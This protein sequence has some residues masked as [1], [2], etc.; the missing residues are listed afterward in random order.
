MSISFNPVK[1]RMPKRATLSLQLTNPLG[2]ADLLAHGSSN[3]RGWGQ[4]AFPDQSLLYVRGFDPATQ[5]YR[6]EVNQRFGATNQAL[7]GFRTP[8]TL[9]A[10]LRFDVGPTRERQLLTQQLNRGRTTEGN[11][12]PEQFIKAIYGTG[13]IPNPMSTILRQQDSLKLSS[14]QADSIAGMNRAYLIQTDAIWTPVAKYFA[15]LPKYYDQGVAY[16]RYMQARKA[17]VDLLMK[18]AP[19][20]KD[21]LS[22]EQRRKLPP[23]VASYLEPRYLASIRSGTATFT[24]NS[25]FGAGGGGLAATEV[26]VAGVAGPGAGGGN[27]IIR[28]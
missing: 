2:A 16:D 7:G 22:P 19:T 17:S 11:K 26:F 28:Q 12:V 20:V 21:L 23:L 3:L 6:Y 27:I 18:I 14:I 24:G 4:Q 13:S 25:G 10:M 5:R 15:E 8:V 1:V 9:T